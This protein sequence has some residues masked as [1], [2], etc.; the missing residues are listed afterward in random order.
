VA[1]S[2]P[3]PSETDWRWTD[4][5]A[6][7]ALGGGRLLEVEVGITISYWLHPASLPSV[8]ASLG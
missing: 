8:A 4:G 1:V 5:A 2:P 6:A 7:L 3:A